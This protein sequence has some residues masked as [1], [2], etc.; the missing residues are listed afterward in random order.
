[1]P[2][3]AYPWLILDCK[4]LHIDIPDHHLQLTFILSLNN[5]PFSLQTFIYHVIDSDDL[6]QLL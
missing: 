2:S 6:Q 5:V 1:M 3:M 4:N